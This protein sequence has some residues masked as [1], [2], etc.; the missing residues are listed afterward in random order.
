MNALYEYIVKNVSLNKIN[1]EVA[2]HLIKALKNLKTKIS[3]DIA[4]IGMAINLP[5]AED[6]N[7]FWQITEKGVDCCREIPL[8]R[9]KDLDRYVA[10]TGMMNG[11]VN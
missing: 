7:Q 6:L 9:K 4:I 8:E 2:I 1:K 3:E 5:L 10:F 11:K